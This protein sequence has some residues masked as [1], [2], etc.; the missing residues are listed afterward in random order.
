MEWGTTN[1]ESAEVERPEFQESEDVIEMNS[2]VNGEPMFFF[3][4]DEK[5]KRVRQ[6]I[7]AISGLMFA[8]F[9]TVFGIFFF[10]AWTNEPDSV[11][12]VEVKLGGEL[13]ELKLGSLIAGFGNAILITIMNAVYDSVK[14]KLNDA[15]NWSTNTQYEDALI[16]K[17]FIFKFAN[18][19][20]ALFYIAF[21]KQFVIVQLILGG[22]IDGFQPPESHRFGNHECIDQDCMFE[23]AQQLFSIFVVRIAVSNGTEILIP[24]LKMV[25]LGED[26]QEKPMESAEMIYEDPNDP[27]GGTKRMRSLVEIEFDLEEYDILMGPFEDYI[28]MVLQFGYATLF[29]A[30]YPIAPVLSFI[31]NYVELRLDAFHLAS[32]HRRAI[33]SGA[34]DIGS[35]EVILSTMGTLAV[36]SNCALLVFTGN[37]VCAQ[38]QFYDNDYDGIRDTVN[39]TGHG[40]NEDKYVTYYFNTFQESYSCVP[41]SMT[42]KFIFFLFLEHGL[43][44]LKFIIALAVPDVPDEVQ[45]QIDRCEFITDKILKNAGDDLEQPTERDPIKDEPAIIMYDED[46]DTVLKIHEENRVRIQA[47]KNMRDNRDNE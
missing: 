1:F 13:Y 47:R 16:L 36:I 31:N 45:I 2:P 25:A 5:D 3:P 38:H 46:E 20:S 41:I 30:A 23:L 17:T 15:E 28:E 12:N 19:Y 39:A 22:N 4:P 10:K 6:S 11:F 42:D 27:D 33:P 18:S 29:T 24:F 40:H 44:I 35:W 21:I 26:D 34:Q 9:M 8:V 7:V 37:Y 32:A 14:C 43:L